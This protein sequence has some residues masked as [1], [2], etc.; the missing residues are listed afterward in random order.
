MD[1]PPVSEFVTTGQLGET[2]RQVQEIVI[3][4]VCEKMKALERQTRPM[5]GFEYE[6]PPGYTRS[7]HSSLGLNAWSCS[8][9][10]CRLRIRIQVVNTI[11]GKKIMYGNFKE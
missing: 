2:L 8:P 10:Y 6:P 5:W 7:M 3:Q 1:C 9:S 11:L 4:V